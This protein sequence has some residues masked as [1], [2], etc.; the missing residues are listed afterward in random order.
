[1]Q[2][3][4]SGGHFDSLLLLGLPSSHALQG[5]LSRCTRAPAPVPA[6]SAVT[7]ARPAARSTGF[8]GRLVISNL[9]ASERKVF[10]DQLHPAPP[11]PAPVEVVKEVVK[12]VVREARGRAARRHKQ[13]Q[14]AIATLC[15][16]PRACLRCAAARSGDDS[17][18]GGGG[19]WI[20]CK[21]VEVKVSVPAPPPEE[22][23]VLG[24]LLFDFG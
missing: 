24:R 18:C 1:M 12:E 7:P 19:R 11:S 8:L 4:A 16:R 21:Q 20:P 2:L 14:L 3:R 15:M 6:D 13:P 17:D 22:H 5:G 23:P 9:S 10:A